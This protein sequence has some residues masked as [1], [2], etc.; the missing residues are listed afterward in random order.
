[1]IAKSFYRNQRELA[2]TLN[3][4]VDMYWRNELDEDLLIQNISNIY[5]NNR[6]KILKF[7]QFTKILQQQCG[8]KRLEVIEKIITK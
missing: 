6:G 2:D 4:L 8:K 5:M 7:D 3:N 1:M